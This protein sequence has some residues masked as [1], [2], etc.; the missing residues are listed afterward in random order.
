ME[1]LPQLDDH[2]VDLVIVHPPYGTTQ[3][4]YDTVIDIEAMWKELRRIVKP[5][6]VIVIF[7]KMP[8]TAR[9]VNSNIDGF[10]QEYIWVKNVAPNF[11]NAGHMALDFHENIIVF[12]P[13][14]QINVYNPQMTTGTPYKVK[15]TGKDDSGEC[16]GKIKQRTDTTNDGIRNPK[17]VMHH[18]R[19]PNNVRC[20][21]SQK[22]CSLLDY[23][24]RTYSNEG[25]TVLDFA[26]G[27]GSTGRSALS[28]GRKFIG[29]EKDK[30]TFDCA[31]KRLSVSEQEWEKFIVGEK[32]KKR[33]KPKTDDKAPPAKRTKTDNA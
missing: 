9:L 17:T 24:V 30:E 23:F 16:Y 7:S 2:S 6:G 31:V 11:L 1:Y 29:V 18:D 5:N 26:M 8:F 15:R 14:K 13:S 3:C 12:K 32:A 21:P 19:V 22:P 27:S 4:K 33:A 28:N 25:D 10:H 20:H